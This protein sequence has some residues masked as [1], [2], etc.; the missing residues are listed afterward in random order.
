MSD[1]VLSSVEIDL[2]SAFKIAVHKAGGCV[3]VSKALGWD[4]SRISIYGSHDNKQFPPVHIAHAVDKLAGEP[5]CLSAMAR[6]WGFTLA[7]T[8]AIEA[9]HVLSALGEKIK[10]SG[11]VTETMARA[12][13]DGR[14]SNNEKQA[15]REKI[16]ADDSANRLLSAMVV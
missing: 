5:L 3:V 7:P 12:L 9:V 16:A 2:K 11:G 8:D 4:K 15:I 6:D 13:D 10:S 14:L 1:L